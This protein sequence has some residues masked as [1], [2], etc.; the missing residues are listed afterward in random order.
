MLNSNLIVVLHVPDIS[1]NL[2]SVAQIVKCGHKVKFDVRGC[3][4]E[5]LNDEII[6]TANFI[7]GMFKI[8]SIC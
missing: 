4:I 8:N 1:A 2:L 6:G 3:K 7:N 5:N